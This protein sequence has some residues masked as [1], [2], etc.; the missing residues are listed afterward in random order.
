LTSGA[1]PLDLSDA[2]LNELNFTGNKNYHQNVRNLSL[3]GALTATVH[4]LT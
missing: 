2:E 1:N 4:F 3:A